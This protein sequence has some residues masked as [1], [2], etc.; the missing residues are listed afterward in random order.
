MKW[1]LLLKPINMYSPNNKKVYTFYRH[2]EHQKYTL[3]LFRRTRL[4]SFA[5]N[6][7]FLTLRCNAGNKNGNRRTANIRSV[8]YSDL[9]VLSKDDL[10]ECLAEYPEAKSILI[11]KGRQMLR[12]D[13]LLDEELAKA[14]VTYAIISSSL[15]F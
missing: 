7:I 13:N 1:S 15:Y 8:G 9:F 6:T 14:Q 3:H 2:T 10:W 11:E 12:K 5:I 4:F